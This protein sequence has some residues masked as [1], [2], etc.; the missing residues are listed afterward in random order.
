[1]KDVL[2]TQLLLKIDKI[3]K[4]ATKIAKS[5]AELVNVSFQG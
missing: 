5:F 2:A 1:M 4:A 3:Y